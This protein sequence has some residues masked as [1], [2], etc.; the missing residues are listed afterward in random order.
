[1]SKTVLIVLAFILFSCSQG[2]KEPVAV[3]VT[4]EITTPIRATTIGEIPVPEGFKRIPAPAGSFASWLRAVPLKKDRTVYLFNGSVKRNQSAQFA[5]VDIPVG[6]KDLQQCADVVMR[7]RAAYLFSQKKY[8]QIAFMDY[9]GK[10]YRCPEGATSATFEAYLQNVFNWCGSASLEKQLKAVADF[11]TIK[12][13]DV[14]IQGG[15][16]GH[17]VTVVD[18]AVNDKGEKLF[19][20]AQGYQP[21]QDIH[22]L[23]NPIDISISPWY[24]I[25]DENKIM[26]PEW[27]F[28]KGNLKT[29][30]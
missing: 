7:F 11:T 14:L 27:W 3:V 20:L 13:G 8:N 15:F 16:P 24:K 10:W 29:W 28:V 17:A 12:S 21:A 4:K 23:V 18:M 19:M 22:V 9:S 26:T 6:K 30:D 5:V 2:K 1:M 25:T